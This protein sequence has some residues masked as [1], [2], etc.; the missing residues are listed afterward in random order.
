MS[1]SAAPVKATPPAPA[2]ATARFEQAQA[3]STPSAR[4]VED[5]DMSDQDADAEMEVDDEFSQ[6]HTPVTRRAPVP[7]QHT[8]HLEVQRTRVPV[9]RMA[10]GGANGN[11]AVNGARVASRPNPGGAPPVDMGQAMPNVHPSVYGRHGRHVAHPGV[12]P[13]NVKS[14]PMY[15]D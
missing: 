10:A 3:G 15:M 14:D 1:Y 2:S 12:T 6:M 4:S 8:P 9:Q 11:F 5:E 7:Q 13:M